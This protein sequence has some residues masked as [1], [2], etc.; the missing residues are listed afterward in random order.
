MMQIRETGV[1]T[2]SPGS[3]KYGVREHKELE[4]S[5]QG[6]F[7]QAEGARDEDGVAVEIPAGAVIWFN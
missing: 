5:Q 7:K 3:H 1:Y 2:L 6:E 4:G